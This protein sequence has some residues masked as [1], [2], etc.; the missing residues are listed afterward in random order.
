V[1]NR[2]VLSP[3]PPMKEANKQTNKQTNIKTKNQLNYV[4]VFYNFENRRIINILKMNIVLLE[5]CRDI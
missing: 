3:P 1:K 2:T 5:T 4:M